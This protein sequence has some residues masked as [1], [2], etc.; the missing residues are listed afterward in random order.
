DDDYV[1]RQEDFVFARL[2]EDGVFRHGRIEDT[3]HYHQVMPRVYGSEVR[4]R[5]IKRLT[6]DM[7]MTE[8]E[9]M[10]TAETQLRGTIKYL[11][12]DAY[13]IRAVKANVLMLQNLG[14]LDFIGFT[15]WVKHTNPEWLPH[16]PQPERK[17]RLQKVIKE[18]PTAIA[19]HVLEYLLHRL[20]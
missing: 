5:K 17:A 18:G 14:K 10:H 7:E 11:R 3:F 12:P 4:A 1:Y 6:V 13:Q 2:V 15:A 20:G 19:R 8:T 16:I 9:E